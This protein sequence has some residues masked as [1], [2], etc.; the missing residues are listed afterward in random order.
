MGQLKNTLRMAKTMHPVVE[1]IAAQ[2]KKSA[3]SAK[4]VRARVATPRANTTRSTIKNSVTTVPATAST[5]LVNNPN[6]KDVA[7]AT[8]STP[9]AQRT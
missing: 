6:K 1:I 8:P 2:V 7:E 9:R 5:L 4:L 3:G